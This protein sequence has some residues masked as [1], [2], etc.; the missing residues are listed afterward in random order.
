M[1]LKEKVLSKFDIKVEMTSAQ[2]YS[3]I[4]A[5]LSLFVAIWSL[6]L[7]HYIKKSVALFDKTQKFTLQRGEVKKFDYN[8]SSLQV[9]KIDSDNSGCSVL[10]NIRGHLE[11]K[12]LRITKTHTLQIINDQGVTEGRFYVLLD[13]V[14]RGKVRILLTLQNK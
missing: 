9:L 3:I 11:E 6:V 2:L 1:G 5:V 14:K 4:L 13:E 7:T 12:N 10:F 8:L